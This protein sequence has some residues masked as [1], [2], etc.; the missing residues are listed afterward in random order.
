MACICNSY[1]NYLQNFSKNS[2]V[3]LYRGFLRPSP[4]ECINLEFV[5][6]TKSENPKEFL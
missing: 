1:K 3:K 5:S 2:S 4:S 6:K